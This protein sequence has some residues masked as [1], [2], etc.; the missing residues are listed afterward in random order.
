MIGITKAVS[1]ISTWGYQIVYQMLFY[2]LT[3][4]HHTISHGCIQWLNIIDANLLSK[5]TGITAWFVSI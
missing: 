4:N 1:L 2:L 3:S 5:T